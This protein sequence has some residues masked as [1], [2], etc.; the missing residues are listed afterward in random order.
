MEMT[1]RQSAGPGVQF[2]QGVFDSQVGNE[3]PVD[4]GG[5]KAAGRIVSAV[6]ADDGKSVQITLDVPD[7]F[8]LP[9]RP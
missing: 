1:F 9:T 4:L 6:V 2:A 8:G 7:G 5:C 3:I